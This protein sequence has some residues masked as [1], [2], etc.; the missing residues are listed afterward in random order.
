VSAVP[1]PCP[2]PAMLRS[3]QDDIIHPK[4]DTAAPDYPSAFLSPISA[5]SSS[6]SSS[7]TYSSTS[8]SSTSSPSS[9]RASSPTGF[10]SSSFIGGDKQI[11]R[12]H[13]AADAERIAIP[14]AHIFGRQDPYYKESLQL[15]ELC[16][17]ELVST[18]EHGEGHWVP[19]SQV[20]SNGIARTIETAVRRSELMV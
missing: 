15:V 8:A 17:G 20:V 7:S 10:A 14:T 6:S 9:S 3:S 11:L 16:A 13:A 12:F 4:Y 19:R 18:F 5:S 2:K 1:K